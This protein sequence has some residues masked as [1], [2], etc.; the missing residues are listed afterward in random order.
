MLH[1]GGEMCGLRLA[2]SYSQAL[3]SIHDLY[4][5]AMII[6][7]INCPTARACITSKLDGWWLDVFR[8]IL[9]RYFPFFSPQ[10]VQHK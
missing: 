8:K 4:S 10:H 2:P 7:K 3:K 6:D 9:T 5:L 1:S